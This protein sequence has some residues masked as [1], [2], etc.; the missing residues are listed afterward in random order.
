MP[1]LEGNVLEQSL[2]RNL[3]PTLNAGNAHAEF[4]EYIPNHK[5]LV[6]MAGLCQNWKIHFQF[7]RIVA[8]AHSAYTRVIEHPE[9]I[10][11][12][13]ANEQAVAAV[14]AKYESALNASD[15]ESVMPLYTEDG[16]FMSPYSHSAVGAAAVRN[17][18]E[19]VFKAITLKVKFDVAEVVQLAPEWIFA[20]TNS[21]GTTA[22]HLTGA[23]SAE[24]NQ[25][26]FI[27]KKETDGAWKIARYS[28][29]STNPPQH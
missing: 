3:Q 22:D 28:F 12:M 1:E 5:R 29:S 13:N 16:V 25:E 11:P 23:T 18:Y 9:G 7:S 19:A 14:L 20:R 24:G 27:F 17:A 26:L 8:Q 15:T 2:W 4:G 21:A 10:K 6:K